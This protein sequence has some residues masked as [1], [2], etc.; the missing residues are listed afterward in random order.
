MKHLVILTRVLPHHSIGGMQAVAWDLAREFVHAGARVSILTTEIKG[1]SERFVDQDVAIFAVPGTNWRRYGARWWRRS[2]E[3]FQSHLMDDCDVVLSISAGAI[4]L[5]PLRD[6][7]PGTPF[8]M[9]AHG[10]SW[11][12]AVS[13]WRTLSA[14]ALL[15]SLRNLLWVVKDSLAYR[16]FDAIVAVG[17]AVANDLRCPPYSWSIDSRRIH[18]IANGVDTGKFKASATRRTT[19]RAQNGWP[20]DAKVVVT[21]CRLHKQKGVH[22]GINAFALLATRVGSARYLIIG[23]GPELNALKQQAEDLGLAQK[24]CFTGSVEREEIASYLQSADVMLFSTT[25][26]EGLPLN[27]LEA[28]A[29]GLPSVISS[30][31]FEVDT[32]PSDT[33]VLQVDPRDAPAVANAMASALAMPFAFTPVL[34]EEYSLAGCARAYG[35]L[36]D[37]LVE[38]R[39][40]LEPRRCL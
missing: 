17:Q 9:Q 30:H 13:K 35:R 16:Q 8:V 14:K 22:L 15:T 3:Y 25:R 19:L 39:Q 12:E 10:T 29:C 31:L 21:A 6:K 11:G 33:H 27:V 23:D 38:A 34:K 7:M 1:K 2:R 37:E 24:I 5:L 28:L 26:V 32:K 40:A 18:A 4:G 20:D 36:F